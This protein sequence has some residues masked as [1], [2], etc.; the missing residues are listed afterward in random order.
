MKN[1]YLLRFFPSKSA[2]FCLY[3]IKISRFPSKTLRE[4]TEVDFHRPSLLSNQ[5]LAC[6]HGYKHFRVFFLAILVIFGFFAVAVI[7]SDLILFIV[8]TSHPDWLNIIRTID[9]S[10]HCSEV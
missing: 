1:I 5:A 7:L 4:R 10:V 6:C 2:C 3:F 9:E 8:R